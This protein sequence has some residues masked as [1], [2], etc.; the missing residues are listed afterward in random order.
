MVYVVRVIL[1]DGV[2]SSSSRCFL[3][4]FMYCLRVLAMIIPSTFSCTV[5]LRTLSVLNK[6]CKWSVT[7]ESEY[8]LPLLSMKIAP[9]TV[10]V[11]GI[12]I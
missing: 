11:A 2:V 10:S 7:S 4:T 1:L 5:T 8:Y 6:C 12:P 9:T 3:S